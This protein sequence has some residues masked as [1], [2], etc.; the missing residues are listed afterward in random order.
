MNKPDYIDL[1]EGHMA[2][3][4]GARALRST[5]SLGVENGF[6]LERHKAAVLMTLKETKDAGE[7]WS[8][9]ESLLSPI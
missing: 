3:L 8:H 5:L 6:I 4:S 2:N 9:L 7:G 1:V